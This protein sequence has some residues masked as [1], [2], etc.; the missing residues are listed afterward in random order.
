MGVPQGSILGPILF[1][2]FSDL[3]YFINAENLHNFSDDNTLTDQAE[4]FNIISPKATNR[5]RTSYGLDEGKSYDCQPSKFHTILFSTDKAD[6][7]GVPIKIKDQ[8]IVKKKQTAEENYRPISLL[9]ICGK[10]FENLFSTPY[11]SVF[12]R[13]NFSLSVSLVLDQLTQQ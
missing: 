13:T 2:L 4:S 11:T 7:A 9:P 6:T 10:M 3:Y 8:E 1:N 5:R 12:V